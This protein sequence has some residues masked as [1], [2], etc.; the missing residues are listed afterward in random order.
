MVPKRY[1]PPSSERGG[2]RIHTLHQFTPP[3]LHSAMRMI[4]NNMNNVMMANSM[5]KN[6][7]RD[8]GGT[9]TSVWDGMDWILLP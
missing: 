9:A 5:G 4:K 6:S 1:S 3:S 7:I 8:G 2:I